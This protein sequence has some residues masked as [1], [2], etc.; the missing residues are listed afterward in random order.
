MPNLHDFEVKLN[1]GETLKLVDLKGKKVLLVNTASQCGLTPQYAGLQELAEEYR[2]KLAVIGFPCNQ[3]GSQ[4]PGSD[5]DIASFCDLNYGVDFPL[6]VKVEVNGEAAAPLFKYATSA[7][8]GLLGSTRIK[9]NFTKFL[10][11]EDGEPVKRFSPK[12]KPETIRK[13]I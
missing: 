9:W 5:D 12:D 1:N 4:E 11:D 10:F 2:D 6:S 8:P 3:F 7:L 13:F